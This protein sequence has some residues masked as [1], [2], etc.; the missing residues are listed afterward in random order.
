MSL[1]MQYVFIM[2][3]VNCTNA[4]TLAVV[5]LGLLAVVM[6]YVSGSRMGCAICVSEYH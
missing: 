3:L 1:R 4:A 6:C 5:C 2:V